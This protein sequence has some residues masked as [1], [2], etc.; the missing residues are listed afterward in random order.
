M[1]VGF[2]VT[3]I[4]YPK[5]Y[6]PSGW[7]PASKLLDSRVSDELQLFPKRA[8]AHEKMFCSFCKKYFLQVSNEEPG[9][10]LLGF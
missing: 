4:S 6:K 3:E 2:H 7:K 1:Y 8:K 9:R 10:M 5:R